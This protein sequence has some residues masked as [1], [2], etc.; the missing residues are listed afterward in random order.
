MRIKSGKRHFLPTG[1]G[2]TWAMRG[3]LLVVLLF[4]LFPLVWNLYSSFKTNA[5][6]LTNP[7]SLPAGL[8]WDNYARAFEK[9]NLLSNLGNSVYV[10][11]VSLTVLVVCVVPCAYCLSRFRFPGS[12]MMMGMY[13]AAIF[14]QAAYIMIPL[15]LQMN[16]MGWL[17]Q[18]TPIAVLYAVM[19]FPF[20]IFLLS[21]YMRAIPHDFEEAAMIDGCNYWGVLCR[22]IIPMSKP[23]IVTVSMLSAMAAWNEYPIALVMLMDPTKQTLPVGLANL[24]EVQRYAT[25]WGALFAALVLVL[26]PTVLLFVVGQKYLMQGI[27]VGGVKG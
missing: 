7:F 15:F 8:A 21:G 27:N 22:V 19:Q 11:L 10:V 25:D 13:M 17:N 24:Y 18:L 20:S 14:I 6:F 4:T 9:S 16:S 12:K 26:I 1:L 2:A 23:G 3:F 5:E